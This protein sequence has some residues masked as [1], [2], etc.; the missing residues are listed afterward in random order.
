MTKTSPTII[1][2]GNERLSTAFDP[3][4]APT[5]EA[6]I[7]HDY[8]VAAVVS[9]YEPARSRKSRALEIEAVAQK[10]NIPLLLPSKLSEITE[11]LKSYH[12]ECGVL[13]AYGKIIP[14]SIIDIFPKGIVNIH[15]SMLPHYRGSI[16][17]E[18]AML[19][20]A[21]ATGV[22]LMKLVKE[23]D[24][25]PLFAQVPVTIEPQESKQALTERLLSIGGELLIAHLP[26][27]LDGSLSATPQ[28]E[29]KA[30][31]T[32]LLTKDDGR[33][34]LAQTA[35]QIE[36]QIRAYAGWPKSTVELSGQHIIIKKA[37]ISATAEDGAL[38]IACG[39]GTFLEILEL[40]APSG[41]T[42]NGSDF[43][44]GYLRE[45]V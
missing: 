45:P 9:N 30:T 42:M 20:G 26:A 22:S 32:K 24:A 44:R 11:T 4:G 1:F 41:R 7:A 43:I 2:F 39:Q 38:V 14:Q 15:P 19:D 10:H 35:E 28:D 25:G 18:Q 21:S 37:R 8:Q 6:L 33:V 3:H 17:I 12:A 29:S 5:L 23:M 31:Y 16:P 27:I 34:D 40:T 13:V 36:R